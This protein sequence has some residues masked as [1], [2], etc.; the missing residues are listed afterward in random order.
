[1]SFHVTNLRK[2]SE[3]ATDRQE[4]VAWWSQ[5]KLRQA[6]ILVI[7]AGALGNEVL[8][9]LALLGVGH[10]VVV[11]FDVIELSNLSRTT[12]FRH[13]DLGLRKAPVA[14]ARAQELCV[15][16]SAKVEALDADVVWEVGLGIYR[17]MDLVLGCLDNVEARLAVNRACLLAHK[18]FIDGGIRGLAG[19]VYAFAP[20]FACCFNCT[21]T[22][23]ER[24]AA[25]GRYDSCFQIIRRNYS[26]GR[27]A[28]VQVTSALIAAL[29]VEQALKWLHGRLPQTGF[30]LQYDGG[31]AVPYFDLTPIQRRPGCECGETQPLTKVNLLRGDWATTTLAECLERVRAAGIREPVLKF[32]SSF[33]PFLFCGECNQNT[34][35]M[36]PIYRLA[37]EEVQCAFCRKI[38]ARESLQL[39]RLGDSMDV[40]DAL[41]EEYR[42]VL[43]KL[44]LS[45]LGFPRQPVLL[46]QDEHG[47]AHYFEFSE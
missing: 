17:R 8:K 25:G 10:M 36:K 21:T 14:A 16:P 33:V 23:R 29:Q 27:M 39:L 26:A 44:P 22:K 46:V 24:Q 35:L 28:T 37:N 11:D 3:T 38:G 5:E 40:Q 12:L 19:S 6:K 20:P 4:R 2:P 32:P 31:G 9:N 47:Q 45:Q 13:A 43:S 1:M 34:K 15:E 30:R 7:G 18:P 41:L 42:D